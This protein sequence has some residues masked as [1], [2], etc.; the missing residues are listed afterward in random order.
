MTV[1][2]AAEGVEGSELVLPGVYAGG[3]DSLVEMAHK[4]SGGP[5]SAKNGEV[6]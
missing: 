3:F 2:H 6:A 4:V 1:V 5:P